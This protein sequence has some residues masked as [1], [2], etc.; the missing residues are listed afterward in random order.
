MNIW[1]YQMNFYENFLVH[2]IFHIWFQIHEQNV[3]RQ[4][5]KRISMSIFTMKVK[6]AL[7]N[8]CLNKSMFDI[9]NHMVQLNNT[10][11]YDY[12]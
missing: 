8:L 11:L 9:Y 3:K 10:Y 4:P 6:R 7:R 5:Q 12:M 1:N 2:E